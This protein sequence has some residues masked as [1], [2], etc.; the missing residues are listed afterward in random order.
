VGLL[1]RVHDLT[2]LPLTCSPPPRATC[3]GTQINAL[4]A[5]PNAQ[6]DANAPDNN[7]GETPRSHSDVPCPLPLLSYTTQLS[8][9]LLF[10]VPAPHIRPDAVPAGWVRVDLLGVFSLWLPG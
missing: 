1:V 3:S 6:P 2:H 10:A 5:Q 4:R 9:I 7:F 8:A